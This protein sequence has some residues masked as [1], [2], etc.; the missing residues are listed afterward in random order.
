MA[1]KGQFN[2]RRGFE[3]IPG[4]A[5]KYR[6]LSTGKVISRRQYIK[7]TENE[8]SLESKAKRKKREREVSGMPTP[9]AR[10]NAVVEQFKLKNGPNAKVRGESKDARE[11]QKA[12]KQL[13][14]NTGGW[15]KEKFISTAARRRHLKALIT[16]G[17]IT[18]AEYE[19]YDKDQD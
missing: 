19:R 2:A 16:L 12:Y 15:E 10:Y 6:D 7:R 18:K 17:I 4:K 5:R 3:R 9:Q 11:F 1:K 14:E 13:K 8:R